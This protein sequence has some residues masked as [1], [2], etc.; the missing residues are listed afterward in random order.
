MANLEE[1]TIGW[2]SLAADNKQASCPALAILSVR[3]LQLSQAT[4]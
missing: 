2:N 4:Q 1:V 3:L